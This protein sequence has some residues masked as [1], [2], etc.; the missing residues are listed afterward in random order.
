MSLLPVPATV[1]NYRL[2]PE[3]SG[4][5]TATITN[6]TSLKGKPAVWTTVEG[7]SVR[8]VKQLTLNNVTDGSFVLKIGKYSTGPITIDTTGA[9]L[10]EQAKITSQAIQTALNQLNRNFVQKY[11]VEVQ[12]ESFTADLK[13]WKITFKAPG[14]ND[15][16]EMSVDVTGL[17]GTNNLQG[18][19]TTLADGSRAGNIHAFET[20]LAPNADATFIFGSA[21]LADMLAAIAVPEALRKTNT[22]TIDTS[23]LTANGH[24]LDIDFSQVADELNFNFEQIGAVKEVQPLIIDNT[25]EGEFAL[26]YKIQEVQRLAFTGAEQPTGTFK[27]SFKDP[28][29]SNALK[30]PQ[31][32]FRL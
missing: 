28:G 13:E 26:D 7:S 30:P 31:R 11:T 32:R 15:V 9:T 10:A 22:V 1:S 19:V 23:T 21:S 4:L 14:E 2:K 6:A 24:V 18:R 17:T 29:G 5:N 16:A 25:T 12:T 8:E 27:I 3:I 20:I